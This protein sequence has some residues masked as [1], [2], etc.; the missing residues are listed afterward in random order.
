VGRAA[1]SIEI[2]S[3]TPNGLRVGDPVPRA[4]GVSD[5]RKAC[6]SVD[7]SNVSPVVKAADKDVLF[8]VRQV[9][10]AMTKQP[11]H[12]CFESPPSGLSA[13]G[14]AAGSGL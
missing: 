13:L 7:P 5:S 4:C 2:L 14:L 3:H 9:A 8:G 12:R 11:F 1:N 10:P 6:T